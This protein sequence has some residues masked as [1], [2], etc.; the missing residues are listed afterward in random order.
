MT[1]EVAE[2]LDIK[3]SSGDADPSHDSLVMDREDDEDWDGLLDDL[4]HI[5]NVQV[6]YG[7]Q[8]V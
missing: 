6:C 2:G 7:L 8:Y 4:E 1:T 3:S 5:I